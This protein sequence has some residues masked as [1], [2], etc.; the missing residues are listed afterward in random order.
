MEETQYK[1]RLILI[2]VWVVMGAGV[3]ISSFVEV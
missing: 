2:L 1:L 3:A